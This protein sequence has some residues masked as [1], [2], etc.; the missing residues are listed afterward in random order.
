VSRVR[1]RRV[2]WIGAAAIL[3]VAA[4][5]ALGAIAQGRFSDTDGRILLTL[6]ALLYTGGAALAGLALVDRRIVATLGWLVAAASPVCLALVSWAIWSFVEEG[7]SNATPDKLAW[8]SVLVLLAGLLAATA[9]LLARRR[10]FV[11][12]AATSGVLSGAA[13]ALSVVGIW[14]EPYHDAYVKALAAL[15][16]LAALT[17]FLVPV[18]QRFT[19]AGDEESPAR[20]VAALDGVELVASR[21]PVEGVA[22]PALA[23]GEL[24]FLRRRD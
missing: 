9:L 8:S 11:R 16:I 14:T 7:E 20:V 24:L 10:A 22:V 3:V 19:A 12:L 4:L 17:Y 21:H 5:V 13:A 15:W 18:L 6:T 1:L 2:F 23:S